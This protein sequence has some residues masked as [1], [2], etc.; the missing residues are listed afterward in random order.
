[1]VA[2]L[3]PP[4]TDVSVA[5]MRRRHLRQVLDI[6]AL[7]YPRP[8]SPSLFASELDA[9]HR[10][11][12]VALGEPDE[13]V[14]PRSLRSRVVLGYAGLM[15]QVDEAHITTVAVHPRH[16]RRK[17]ASHLL[18]SLL[19]EAV[20]MGADAVT[21][22]V[23]T[24]NRGAQRLYANFGFAPVGVRPGYYAETQED[25]VV[26]WAYDVGAPAFAER[27]EAQRRRLGAPGGASGAPDLHVP[28]VQGR[29]GLHG[30]EGA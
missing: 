30:E 23:R 3:R 27:L 20:A 18:V 12:L 17:V 2:Q 15:L 21:L 8:W 16:H 10:C 14:W 28:W 9:P 5:P 24:A 26:M 13:S 11:Y 29:V 19:S 4:V 6:E 7:V 1:V 25:A 22:E